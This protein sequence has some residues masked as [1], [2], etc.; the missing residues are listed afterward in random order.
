MKYY[1]VIHNSESVVFT[2]R[3]AETSPELRGARKI[4]DRIKNAPTADV[5]EVKHGKW[6]DVYKGK[7]H[8]QLYVCSICG[9]KAL[10]K[11]EVNELG[12]ERAVQD[13]SLGCHHCRAKMDGGKTE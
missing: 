10:Y 1:K 12:N 5:E 3:N 8:N 11:F 6:V 13:L 4:I 7:Y 9:A 2:V